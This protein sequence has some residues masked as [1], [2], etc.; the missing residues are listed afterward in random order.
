[1]VKVVIFDFGRTLYDRDNNGFFPEVPEILEKLSSRYKLAIV[2]MAVS[3][4]PEERKRILKESNFEK[5]FDSTIF[6]KEDKDSAYEKALLELG[7][8]PVEVAI[9]DDR[10]KRG[11]AW[12]N[13]RGAAT[14]WFR[15]GKFKD[16]LPD[17]ETGE[18]TNTILNLSE[19]LQILN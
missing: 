15:N 4:D 14:I 11:V 2:S 13:K 6:V 19:L 17:G 3:D 5:Y 12:G 7:V 9:V 16:E 8:D 18:P 10:V 1:M